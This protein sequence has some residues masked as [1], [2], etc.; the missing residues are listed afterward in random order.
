[1]VDDQLPI[2][3]EGQ[4]PRLPVQHVPQQGALSL[5]QGSTALDLFEESKAEDGDV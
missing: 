1:M 5:R 4:S 2:G 3:S